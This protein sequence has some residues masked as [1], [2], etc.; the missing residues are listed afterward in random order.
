MSPRGVMLKTWVLV[1]LRQS[2]PTQKPNIV[3]AAESRQ[4]FA[5]TIV[6]RETTCCW[7]FNCS[8]VN[9]IYACDNSFPVFFVAARLYLAWNRQTKEHIK[10]IKN[11]ESQLCAH[12]LRLHSS[13]FMCVTNVVWQDV[14]CRAHKCNEMKSKVQWVTVR[15]QQRRHQWIFPFIDFRH[16]GWCFDVKIHI[17]SLLLH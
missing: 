1:Q 5:E 12:Y 17:E 4:G 11:Y 3:K 14:Y 15:I 13:T 7:L 16:V 2:A 10:A 9:F 6:W 8:H